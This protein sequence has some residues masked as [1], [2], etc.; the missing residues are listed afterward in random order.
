MNRLACAAVFALSISSALFAQPLLITS[1][2]PLPTGVSGQYYPG[3]TFTASGGSATYTWT[4]TGLPSGLTLDPL[5][6]ELTGATSAIGTFPINVK[7]DDGAGLSDTKPFS[8]KIN[9]EI[10]VPTPSPLPAATRNAAYSTF[11][12]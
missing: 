5:T 7:V 8:F 2:A 9:S 1:T 3:Y 11:L 10:I 4:A 6:A 12:A